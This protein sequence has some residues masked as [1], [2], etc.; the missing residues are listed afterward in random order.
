VGGWV[1]G[2]GGWVGGWVGGCLCG[3][4]RGWVGGLVGGWVGVFFVYYLFV[5]LYCR[6]IYIILDVSIVYYM[7]VCVCVCRLCR[8]VDFVQKETVLI[9]P[10]TSNR[11]LT[12]LVTPSIKRQLQA[13]IHQQTLAAI[14][15]TQYSTCPSGKATLTTY[16][17]RQFLFTTGSHHRIESR[18]AHARSEWM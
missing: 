6:H 10:R 9:S 2:G 8:C 5:C 3:W 18:R 7:S 12:Y 16:D 13:P 15:C 14:T 17:F 4:V 1:G 11:K